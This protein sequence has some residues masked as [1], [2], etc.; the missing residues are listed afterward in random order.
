MSGEA[1]LMRT[2]LAK[3]MQ[4]HRVTPPPFKPLPLLDSV[5]HDV[6]VEGFAAP[7]NVDRE[8]TKFGVH[9]WMPFKQQVPLLFRHGRPAGKVLEVRD[10]DNGLYV[11]ALVTDKEAKRAPY[12]SVAAT[13]CGYTLRQPDD[14][15]LFH[16]RVGCAV[17]EEVSLVPDSPANPEAKVLHRYPAP[18]L[19][20]YD[21]GIAAVNKCIQIVELMQRLSA[22]PEPA[23]EESHYIIMTKHDP[24]PRLQIEPHRATP[25]GRLIDAI[26]ARGDMT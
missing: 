4:Q 16:S 24:A 11:R 3:L 14:P 2:Q 17:L 5:D 18:P 21:L 15:E 22:R 13:I 19:Q 7:T 8:R 1:F 23:V 6:I 26:E 12:F 10:T 25:F 9:C 20:F